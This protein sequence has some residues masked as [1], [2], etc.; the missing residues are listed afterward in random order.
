M[1]VADLS[2]GSNRKVT[3]AGA[4]HSPPFTKL[5]SG[6]EKRRSQAIAGLATA[7]PS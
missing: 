6:I 7:A 4:L 1:A 3:S 5:D 2:S